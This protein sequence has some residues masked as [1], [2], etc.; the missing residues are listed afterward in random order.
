M[1]SLLLG[2]HLGGRVTVECA[3]LR[4]GKTIA[5]VPSLRKAAPT[6]Q[7]AASAGPRAPVMAMATSVQGQSVSARMAELKAAGR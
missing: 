4:A 5:G 2:A 6:Q 3:R 1:A 7:R